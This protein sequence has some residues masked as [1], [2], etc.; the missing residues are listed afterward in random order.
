MMVR[1][2]I[3]RHCLFPMPLTIILLTM[4]LAGLPSFRED[5]LSR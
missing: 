2:I 4:A 1:G 5:R 3:A